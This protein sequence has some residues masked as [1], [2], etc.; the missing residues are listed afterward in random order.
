M[1]SVAHFDQDTNN[2][3]QPTTSQTTVIFPQPSSTQEDCSVGTTGHQNTYQVKC[4]LLE[5]HIQEALLIN[6][7]LRSEL[8]QYKEKIDF[9]KKLRKFLVNRVKGFDSQA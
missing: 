6:K 3:Q 2:H 4:N 9:E 5:Y 8:K 7:A 1:E